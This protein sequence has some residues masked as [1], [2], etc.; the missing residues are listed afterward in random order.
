MF[1]E[2]SIADTLR[3]QAALRPAV[4]LTGPRQSGKTTLLR[5]TFG[6]THRYVS[7]DAPDVRAIALA[8]P[9]GFL[10]AF[11]PPL[12]I[13]EVQWAP[14]LLSYLRGDIDEHRDE[15]GRYLLTGSPHL[16]ML[17]HVSET[18]AGRI[19]VLQLHGL[20]MREQAGMPHRPL[21]WEEARA[22]VPKPVPEREALEVDPW[23]QVVRGQFPEPAL[24]PALGAKWYADYVATYLERD[25]RQVRAVSDLSTFQAFLQALAARTGTLLELASLARDLGV[26]HNTA[27][28]W[29][30]VLQATGHVLLVPPLAANLGKRLVKS[31]KVHFLDTGLACYLCG[32]DEPRH[33]ARGPMAGALLETLVVSDVYRT[34]WRSGLPPRIFHW[35]TARGSEVDLVVELVGGR[36]VPIEAKVS[37]TPRREMARP[38][39]GLRRDLGDRVAPGFVACTTSAPMPLGDGDVAVPIGA[40]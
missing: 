10:A 26:A 9:R 8:D 14:E 5:A 40:L 34:L 33:A 38:M 22:A 7:L 3:E 29:L 28:G 12:I 27:R 16:L 36:L 35:R 32:I 17:E 23:E 20:T 37:A 15:A 25:V 18:L 30:S 21:P 19:A 4:L 24:T 39:R 2:R 11:P 1:V 6:D 13:D 31:P